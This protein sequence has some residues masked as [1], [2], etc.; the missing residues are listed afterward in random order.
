M[1]LPIFVIFRLK[2]NKPETGGRWG[3]TGYLE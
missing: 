1:A 3:H 2:K